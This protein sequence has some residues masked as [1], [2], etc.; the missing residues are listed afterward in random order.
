MVSKTILVHLLSLCPALLSSSSSSSST[1]DDCSSISATLKSPDGTACEENEHVFCKDDSSS[2]PEEVL[3]EKST[4]KVSGLHAKNISRH[5]SFCDDHA[6]TWDS[7]SNAPGPGSDSENDIFNGSASD[8]SLLLKEL[9]RPESF[10]D[11]SLFRQPDYEAV[12]RKF[13]VD[14]SDEDHSADSSDDVDLYAKFDGDNIFGTIEQPAFVIPL[15]NFNNIF[16]PV[17]MGPDLDLE[18]PFR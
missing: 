3:C 10:N 5:D 8:R 9:Y 1:C 6:R 15:F 14:S 12:Y 2:S 16:H 17:F 4:R 18:A 11:F 13:I 7:F